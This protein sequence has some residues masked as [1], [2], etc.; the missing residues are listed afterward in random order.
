VAGVPGAL[1]ATAG[2]VS[3]SLIIIILIASMFM[4]FQQ[5]EVVQKAFG[6]IRAAVVAMI[7]MAVIKM[8][9]SAIKDWIGILIAICAVLVILIIQISPIWVILT[10]I[11]LGI[12][13]RYRGEQ[14]Q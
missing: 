2:M 4:E 13:L 10:S 8:G 1:V 3:P 11:C 12:A 6:G 14:K 9:K 5:L 7:L